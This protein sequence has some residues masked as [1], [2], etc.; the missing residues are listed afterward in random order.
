M[1][2]NISINVN[3]SL[4]LTL[5]VEKLEEQLKYIVKRNYTTYFASDLEDVRRLR[6]KA[7]LVTFDDVTK[8]QLLYAVP[9]LEKYK[10]KATFFVPFSFVGKYDT[11]NDGKQEIMSI[12]DLKSLNRDLI[13][14]AHHSFYHRKF[15]E[16]SRGSADDDLSKSFTFI[17]ENKLKVYSAMAL[18]Y[19]KYPKVSWK[20]YDFV[21]VLEKYNFKMAFR[22]G[23]RVNIFPFRNKFLIK[24]IDIKG[25]DSLLKFKF[26]ILFG[27]LSLF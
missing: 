20:T 27:K 8:N 17:S 6:G 18:P 25:E 15:D 19:G 9:L 7:L 1:Y 16:I 21:D 23:N 4:G 11:W 2:H 22:I 5:F 26:K 3:E 13:Q 10:I 14:L 24:R 12:D